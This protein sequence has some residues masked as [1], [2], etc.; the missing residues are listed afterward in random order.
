M[1]ATVWVAWAVGCVEID[2]DGPFVDPFP[3]PDS[4][5]PPAGPGAPDLT[6]TEAD[7]FTPCGYVIGGDGDAQHHNLSVIH[8]GYLVHPW[9]PESGGGGI[10]FLDVS[11]PC[12]P[13]VVGQA[14]ADG[15]RETHSLA[16]G[17]DATGEREF[18]AVDYIGADPDGDIGGVGF[19]DVTDRTAPLWVSELGFDGFHYPDAYVAVTLSTFWQGP[20][21]YVSGGF[22]GVFVVDAS[23]PTMPVLVDRVIFDGLLVGSFHVVGNVALVASAGTARTAV[24][25]LSDPQVPELFPNGA[26]EV[27]DGVGAITNYYFSNLGGDHAWFARKQGG[28]GFI[29]YD[30]TDFANPVFD[31]ELFTAD[32]SGGYVFQAEDHL[33]VGD[34]NFGS[35]YDITDLHEAVEVGRFQLQGDLDTVTPISNVALVSVDSGAMEGQAT[36]VMPWRTAPDESGPTAGFHSPADGEVFVATTGRVGLVF[37]EMVERKSVFE[38]S[39]RVAD[40]TGQPVPGTFNVQESIVNFTPTDGLELNTTY[41]VTVPAGGI[42]DISGNSTEEEV[43]WQFSTGGGVIRR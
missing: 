43:S 11:D 26:F 15:M 42:T 37:D 17:L 36:A 40:E 29:A 8:D 32:G 20:Y 28:G 1:L 14:W 16:F 10:S 27:L 9:A 6:F 25:D 38:G 22:M 24:V 41:T 4:F 12:S 2:G 13:V 21:V 5:D 18:L 7:L 33:F 3:A 30:I 34:S 31:A 19:W 35:V 39:F 23:D